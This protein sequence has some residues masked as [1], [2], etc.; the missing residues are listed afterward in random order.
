MLYNSI[1][2]CEQTA[3]LVRE[4]AYN[5]TNRKGSV[6]LRDC[7]QSLSIQNGH[8]TELRS[9][10]KEKASWPDTIHTGLRSWKQVGRVRQS[11]QLGTST[12]TIQNQLEMND[13]DQF[14]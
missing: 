7:V 1:L 9:E 2:Q 12:G 4:G 11:R 13:S 3:C 5:C 14:E 8:H 10:C 6:H